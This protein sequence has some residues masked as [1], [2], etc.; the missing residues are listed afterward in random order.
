M[1]SAQRRADAARNSDAY[2]DHQNQESKRH[3][4]NLQIN[5]PQGFI[6]ARL[7][8]AFPSSHSIDQPIGRRR[9]RLLISVNTVS[10]QMRLDRKGRRQLFETA[11]ERRC[12]LGKRRQCPSL[13]VG[14][15][16][17]QH[18]GKALLYLLQIFCGF[19]SRFGGR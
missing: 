14:L 3:K 10:E 13:T 2:R 7:G 4:A 17:A 19:R 16:K 1:P 9:H 6:E 11:L 12:A 18:A 8:L 15:R 5:F